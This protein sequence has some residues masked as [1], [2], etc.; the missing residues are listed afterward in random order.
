[1]EGSVKRGEGARGGEGC[2]EQRAGGRQIADMS[3]RDENSI[4]QMGEENAHTRRENE[5]K[6]KQGQP[7]ARDFNP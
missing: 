1:M 3:I 2:E 7:S 5:I 4:E 6:E